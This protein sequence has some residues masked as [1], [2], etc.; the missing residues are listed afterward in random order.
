[1]TAAVAAPFALAAAPRALSRSLGGVALALVT[2]DL[3]AGVVAVELSTGRIHRRIETPPNPSSI[4]TVGQRGALVA[5]VPGGQLTLVDERLRAHEIAGRL[6]EPRYAAVSPGRRYA[7]VTDSGWGEVAVVDLL[8]RAVVRRVAVG[9]SPR[10]LSLAPS[11][12]RLWAVLGNV[13]PEIAVLAIDRPARPRVLARVRPPFAAHDVGF[14][15]GG[16]RVWV[17]GGASRRLAVYAEPSRRLLRTLSSD[18][19]PQHVTFLGGRAYVASGDDAVLRL[20]SVRDGR[21]THS[22]AVPLGSYNVQEGWGVV[23]SPSLTQGT[24]TVLSRSGSLRFRRR[25]A[26]SSHDACFVLI[27]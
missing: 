20:H 13:S 7:Y 23:L 1:V 19:P 9:G 3:E 10:H 17:T 5:H 26:R 16:D 4:E 8:E 21:V 12:R 27:P 24:L 6:A 15:P 25:V 2:A 22:T 18:A 11:G 14:E